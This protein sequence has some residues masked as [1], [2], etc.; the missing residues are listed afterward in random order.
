MP[1]P[2]DNE[3]HEYVSKGYRLKWVSKEEFANAIASYRTVH[4]N[5]WSESREN[6]CNLGLFELQRVGQINAT[7][8]MHQQFFFSLFAIIPH[9][10]LSKLPRK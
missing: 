10:V 5:A 3:A 9:Q 2:G 7:T 8:I 1:P 4:Q 6:L